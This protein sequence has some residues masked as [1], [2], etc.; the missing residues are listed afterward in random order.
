L[1]VINSSEKDYSSDCGRK[2]RPNGS[3]TQGNGVQ[4]VRR[5]SSENEER[6]PI[7]E[8]AVNESSATEEE[9]ILT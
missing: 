7:V 2:I 5:V 9:A 6:E 3:F 8:G 1:I 4:V